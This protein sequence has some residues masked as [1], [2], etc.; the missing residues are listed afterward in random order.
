MQDY[1]AKYAD[2][3]CRNHLTPANVERH[4][5]AA[6][7]VLESCVSANLTGLR[8]TLRMGYLEHLIEDIESRE[9]DDAK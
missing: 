4:I 5:T 2:F 3:Y 1:F 7:M 8:D 9:V 6:K